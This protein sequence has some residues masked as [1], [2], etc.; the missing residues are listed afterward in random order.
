MDEPEGTYAARVAALVQDVID[1][2]ETLPDNAFGLGGDRLGDLVGLVDRCRALMEA[3]TVTLTGEAETRGEIA[4]SQEWRPNGTWIEMSTNDRAEVQRLAALCQAQGVACREA[5]VSGSVHEAEQGRT[6]VWSEATRR[7]TPPKPISSMPS[8][9]R[10]STW[11]LGNT[12]IIKV[13][14]NMLAF[15]HLVAAGEAPMLATSGGLD[16]ATSFEAIRATRVTAS[17]TRPRARWS[18]AAATASG[19]RWI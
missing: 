14:T 18:S 11:A 12:S 17:C 9:T 8:S 4:T 10:S 1:E 13:I 5:P 3:A 6:T 16:L 7:C 19:S 15:V 2:A